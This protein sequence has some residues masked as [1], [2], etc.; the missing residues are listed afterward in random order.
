MLLSSADMNNGGDRRDLKDSDHQRGCGANLCKQ[1]THPTRFPLTLVLHPSFNRSILHRAGD[2]P[3]PGVLPAVLGPPHSSWNCSAAFQ[4]RNDR[5]AFVFE[6]GRRG[7]PGQQQEASEQ[8]KDDESRGGRAL[9]AQRPMHASCRH[10]FIAFL[11]RKDAFFPHQCCHGSTPQRR[12]VLRFRN[13]GYRPSWTA[14]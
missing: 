4:R 7:T 9:H 13:V 8:W 11:P 6:P 12:R 2:V 14:H 10:P 3:E 1:L 5:A